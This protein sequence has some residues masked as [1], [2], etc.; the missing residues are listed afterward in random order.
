MK[1]MLCQ[2]V[3]QV[4]P[5]L[6]ES[7]TET[8]NE[9]IANAQTVL[10]RGQDPYLPA[11]LQHISREKGRNMKPKMARC[12][13]GGTW[14]SGFERPLEMGIARGLYNS[15]LP[16]HRYVISSAPDSGRNRRHAASS[17]ITSLLLGYNSSSICIATAQTIHDH[18]FKS[19][20]RHLTD[21]RRQYSRFQRT[22]RAV[23]LG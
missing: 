22:M 10:R 2:L 18:H 13:L 21:A 16:L 6:T 4:V 17:F 20:G 7:E 19:I 1:D 5:L 14:A 8:E 9:G 11:T 15:Q 23:T 12:R 3:Y